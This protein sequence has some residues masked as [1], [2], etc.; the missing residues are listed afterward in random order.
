[1]RRDLVYAIV[2]LAVLAL[3]IIPVGTAVFLLGFVYGDSPCVMCWEQRTGM[4]LIALIGL[5]ILRY[6]PRP[7]YVGLAVLVGAWGLFMGMRHAGMHAARDVGQ[8]FSLSILGV[9]TYTWALFIFWICIVTMGGLLLLLREGDLQAAPRRLRPLESLAT[10]VFMVV[11]AGNI[12]QAFASTGPPPY[13]GQGDPIRFSFNPKHWVWSL[14]EYSTAPVSLRGRWASEE[15]D[16][17]ALRADPEAGPL[18]GL[19]ALAMKEP[20][21]VAFP[22]KGT[23]TDIAYDAETDRFLLTTQHGIYVSDAALTRVLRYTVVDPGFSVDLGRFAG[24]AFLDGNTVLAVGENKSF[25]ILK[26]NDKADPDKNFRFFL[27]SFDRFDEVS[28][29]RFGTVRARM[30]YTMSAAFDPATTSIYTVTVPNS[31]VRRLVV[32]RFD[33]RD[34]TLSEEF[35]PTLAKDAGLKLG[36]EK[37]SLD[38]YYVTGAAID[39]G[40]MYAI[41][42]AY[43]TL[44]AIDLRTHAVVAAYAVP[45]VSQAVVLAI[46]GDEFYIARAD[47][48]VAVAARPPE[49]PAAVPAGQPQG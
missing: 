41:S 38:E 46:K 28:R 39:N 24:A 4:A 26:E 40:R 7:K 25:V 47:G 14:E 29:S 10:V 32:S 34:L 12:V 43:S 2:A 30:M 35:M 27:E 48:T 36:G 20:K 9:H 45:G 37:R 11:I 18:A 22:V 5:F 49:T 44:V 8:G 16:V 13:V 1:M 17:T 6:G 3:S 31:K 15:P 42:A 33:R 19:P 23:I 21:R